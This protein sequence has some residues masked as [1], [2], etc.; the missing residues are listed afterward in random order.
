MRVNN[1]ELV[2]AQPLIDYLNPNVALGMIRYPGDEEVIMSE[3][4]KASKERLTRLML[5]I[6]IAYKLS[7]I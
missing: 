5:L 3:S 1:I 7:R 2:E 6:A 4:C